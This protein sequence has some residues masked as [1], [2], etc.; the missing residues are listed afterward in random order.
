MQRKL[1]GII[2][3]HF[4]IRGQQVIIYSAFIKFLKKD[5]TAVR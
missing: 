1:V 2:T 5:G 4:D 3:G